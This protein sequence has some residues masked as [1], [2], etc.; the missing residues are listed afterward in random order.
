MMYLITLQLLLHL[1]LVLKYVII[2]G[3]LSDTSLNIKEHRAL[4]LFDMISRMVG[5]S[6]NAF[7]IGNLS[8]TKNIKVE[9]LDINTQIIEDNVFVIRNIEA[10]KV[11]VD[12]KIIDQTNLR[13]DLE[14]NLDISDYKFILGNLYNI[15]EELRLLEHKNKDNYMNTILSI[16]G[17]SI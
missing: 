14:V 4:M 16:L 10:N 9:S 7:V 8:V 1:L 2:T 12:R 6:Y 15:V 3:V 17:S 11:Y 13:E 5:L